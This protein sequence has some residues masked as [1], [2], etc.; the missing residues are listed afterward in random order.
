M[1]E[2][3]IVPYS[4]DY[5]DQFVVIKKIVEEVFT[6]NVLQV[7]HVGSTAVEG[8]GGKSTIDVLVI[9]KNLNEVENLKNKMML[10]GYE[11]LP[12]AVEGGV[13]CVKNSGDERLENI[14]LFEQGHDEIKQILMIRDYLRT[15][16]LEVQDYYNYK[17][18]LVEAFPTNYSEYRRL[19]DEYFV[20]L[21]KRAN[22]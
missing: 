19:K 7:E 15:H 2:Y 8:L 4:N 14:H 10:R 12:G 1:R 9:V 22:I 17:K 16:P 3:K 11:F 5:A 18:T 13:L 6:D 21:L 20:K